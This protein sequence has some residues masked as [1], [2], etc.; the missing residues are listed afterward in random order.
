MNFAIYQPIDRK[1]YSIY[2]KWYFFLHV[3]VFRKSLYP[4]NV[5]LSS[6]LEVTPASAPQVDIRCYFLRPR[7]LLPF[8]LG[9]RL[10]SVSAM[11]VNTQLRKPVMHNETFISPLQGKIFT[12]F[13]LV[14]SGIL[15]THLL[16]LHLNYMRL[17]GDLLSKD[18]DKSPSS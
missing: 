6:A 3:K 1:T 8:E 17:D 14:F 7:L 5:T 9:L 18:I 16:S 13:A 2:S 11:W 12:S 15:I 4:G 10:K